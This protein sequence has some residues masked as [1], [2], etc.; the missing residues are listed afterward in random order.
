MRGIL[1]QTLL[2]IATLCILPSYGSFLV[3]GALLGRDRALEGSSQAWSLVPGVL[4]LYLRRAFLRLALEQCDSSVTVEFGTIF[5][6]TSARLDANVYLGPRCHIGSVHIARDTLV[7][8]GVHI[9]SGPNT[10]GTDDLT[11]PI[12][13]QPGRLKTLHIGEGCWIGSAAVILANVGDGSVVAAGAVV[14]QDLP[15]HVVAGGVPARV[16]KERAA[17]G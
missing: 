4:G 14:T 15:A 7:A 6:R 11:K 1:K 8:A 9:P 5:S 16:I 10:H 17:A 12:R 13:E 2:G 3:R